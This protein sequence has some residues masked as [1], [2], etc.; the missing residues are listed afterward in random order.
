[1]QRRA[2]FLLRCAI[3]GHPVSGTAE[4]KVSRK[5]SAISRRLR[6]VRAFFALLKEVR[7][8]REKVAFCRY[9]AS[10][11]LTRAASG[12]GEMVVNFRQ[13]KLCFGCGAA[14]LQSYL[15]IFMEDDY[16]LAE[17][18][19]KDARSVIIDVGS[20]IGIFSLAAAK[21]FPKTRIYSLE[22]G[23]G[24][25]NRFLQNI[26]L[27]HA[28][29]IMPF[30][31]AAWCDCGTVEFT[32]ETASTASRIDGHSGRA[33]NAISLDAFCREHSIA[34]V[35]LLKIDAEG[36]EVEI[37]K[38]AKEILPETDRVVVE[39][40]SWSLAEEVE[41]TL[42]PFFRKASERRVS[43]GGGMLRFVRNLQPR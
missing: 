29:A 22:P 32:D 33:V 5:Y 42:T 12:K 20:N 34:R 10:G 27:N 40:H 36:A 39:C 9:V 31:A 24:T 26:S 6:Q 19:I 17:V 21:R 4:L 16:C 35:A 1:V 28:T 7:G 41:K 3:L 43:Q 38:G 15:E 2:C 25:F 14:E 23:V 30:N 13:A 11:R 8:L 18:A 37:L